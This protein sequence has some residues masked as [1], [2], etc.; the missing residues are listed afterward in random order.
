MLYTSH[1]AGG[2][3][4]DANIVVQP[5][6]SGER[7][8]VR[9]RGYFGRYVRS[10]HL[11]YIYEGTLFAAPF[12]LDRLEIVGDAV[13]VVEDVASGPSGLGANGA[14]QFAAS[15][16]G[17]FLYQPGGGSVGRPMEWIHR[18]GH[19]EL[20][21]KSEAIWGSP[22]FAP[23]GERVAIQINAG[24]HSDVWVYE[25]LRDRLT[26]LTTDPGEAIRPIWT[27]N[28][29]RIVYSSRRGER[30]IPNLYWRLSDG[31]SDE[32]RLTEGQHPQFPGS[33]H[34]S[35][36]LLAFTER[37]PKTGG[38]LMLLPIEGDETTGWRPGTPAVFLSTPALE[39]EPAFSPDGRWLAYSATESGRSE[40][41]VRAY[42]G[43]GGKW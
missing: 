14:A 16:T 30:L 37:N 26:R 28:G 11:L 21:R 8:I 29:R 36:R 1:S 6:P 31:S 25:W 10:G 24:A 17:I 13:P 5:L 32:Q 3:F 23:D 22:R 39:Q 41:F 38:D 33:W 40:V 19:V 7:K 4:D 20:L 27:P 42:P 35:G 2:N 15:N 9:Q 18:S 43:P 12:S 34:P